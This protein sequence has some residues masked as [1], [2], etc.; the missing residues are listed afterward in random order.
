MI[1]YKTYL[2]RVKNGLRQW[3]LRRYGKLVFRKVFLS[4]EP[5]EQPKVSTRD[6]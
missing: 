5:K 6:P 2:K 4:S 1:V 3:G